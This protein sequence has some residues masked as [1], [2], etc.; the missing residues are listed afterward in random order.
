[1][2]AFPKEDSRSTGGIIVTTNTDWEPFYPAFRTNVFEFIQQFSHQ[3]L[4]TLNNLTH[5]EPEY[6]KRAY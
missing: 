4:T 1:M 5:A 3:R 2:F 6:T